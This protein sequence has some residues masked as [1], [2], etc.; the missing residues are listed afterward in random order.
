VSVAR[1]IE[2]FGY[3]TRGDYLAAERVASTKSEW[4]DGVVYAMAGASKRHVGTVSRMIGILEPLA[5]EHE[6]FVGSNDLMVQT[7]LA[8]YYPGCRGHL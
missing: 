8:N 1:R 6:C 2:G 3:V 5:R 7:E 4:V